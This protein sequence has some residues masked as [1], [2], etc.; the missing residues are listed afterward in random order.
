MKDFVTLIILIFITT[1][2]SSQIKMT[3]PDI[4]QEHK[5]YTV[6]MTNDGIEYISHTINYE[7]YNQTVAC[8]LTE[9]KKNQVQGCTQVL[10]IEPS[11]E[12]KHWIKYF[13]NKNFVKLKGMV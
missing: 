8:Y 4:I 7:N 11:F 13:N 5:N 2:V 9:K 1:T 12:T 10:M 3:K 6:K